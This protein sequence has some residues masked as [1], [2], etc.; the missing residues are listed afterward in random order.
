MG[1]AVASDGHLYCVGHFEGFAEFGG[2]GHPAAGL[3]D[4]FIVGL[5]AL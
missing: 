3:A 1:I 2:E 5:N 4:G